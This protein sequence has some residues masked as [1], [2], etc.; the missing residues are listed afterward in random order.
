[1]TQSIVYPKERPSKDSVMEVKGKKHFKKGVPVT[2][3]L[4]K[5]V[6][7]W[8]KI[9]DLSTNHDSFIENSYTRVGGWKKT[10]IKAQ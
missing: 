5:S 6:R 9:Y 8:K 4:L 1:M 3:E 2:C 7:N 10:A